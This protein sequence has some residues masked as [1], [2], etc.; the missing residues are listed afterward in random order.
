[1][2]VFSEMQAIF[3]RIQEPSPYTVQGTLAGGPVLGIQSPLT[4][5]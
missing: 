3:A 4:M 1:M 5:A 2:C